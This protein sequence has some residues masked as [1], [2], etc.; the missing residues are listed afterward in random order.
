V[1]AIISQAK[2]LNLKTN[3]EGLESK[4]QPDRFKQEECDEIGGCFFSRPVPA[5]EFVVRRAVSRQQTANQRKTSKTIEQKNGWKNPGDGQVQG[6]VYGGLPI[7]EYTL[8]LSCG[9]LQSVS[10][11]TV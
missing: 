4:Q 3:A 8:Q 9:L 10:K 1:D 11:N 2:S 5:N 7:G 6:C